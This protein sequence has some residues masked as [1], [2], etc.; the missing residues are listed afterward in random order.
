MNDTAIT[1][2]T[3][4]AVVDE[5][6]RLLMIPDPAVGAPLRRPGSVHPLHRRARDARSR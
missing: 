3:P 4:A 6:L 1:T 2:P 5:Y